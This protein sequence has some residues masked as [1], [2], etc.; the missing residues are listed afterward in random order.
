MYFSNLTLTT[1]PT[2]KLFKTGQNVKEFEINTNL[3]I[4]V[5]VPSLKYKLSGH[6][7]QDNQGVGQVC[8]E[9]SSQ[10]LTLDVR[11]YQALLQ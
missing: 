3:G 11:Q 8:Y 10:C 4:I 6:K 7:R 2:R 1:I 9:L 5:Q